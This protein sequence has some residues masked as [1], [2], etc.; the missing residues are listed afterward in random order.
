[1]GTATGYSG[2]S[3]PRQ[4]TTDRAGA[5]RSRQ[6]A[7]RAFHNLWIE[8]FRADRSRQCRSWRRTATGGDVRARDPGRRGNEGP[9]SC[10]VVRLQILQQGCR[11]VQ[12][13]PQASD[14][15][16][17]IPRRQKEREG[18]AEG[19]DH[20]TLHPSRL[21]LQRSL[22]RRTNQ[23]ESQEAEAGGKERVPTRLRRTSNTPRDSRP[24]RWWG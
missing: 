24:S 8:A 6:R 13:S 2:L 4:A 1:M 10:P 16:P 23:P 20:W 21:V 22:L 17:R 12:D 7:S 15:S 11:R 19:P 9:R 14:L 18:T 5:E 3:R